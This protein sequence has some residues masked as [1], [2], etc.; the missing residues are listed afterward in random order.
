MV[1]SSGCF[2]IFYVK[3]WLEITK[4]LFKSNRFL[5]FQARMV[6]QTPS[7]FP[8]KI[9][10]FLKKQQTNQDWTDSTSWIRRK[11]ARLLSC[12]F[13]IFHL[14]PSHHIFHRTH[15]NLYTQ[16]NQATKIHIDL[17]DKI[18][19]FLDFISG[20]YRDPKNWLEVTIVAF[21]LES[22]TPIFFGGKCVSSNLT[23]WAVHMFFFQIWVF[24]GEKNKKPPTGCR[25]QLWRT[26]GWHLG[27]KLWRNIRPFGEQKTVGWMSIPSLPLTVFWGRGLI[28]TNRRNKNTMII[29]GGMVVFVG[30]E[31][32]IIISYR[33]FA[34]HRLNAF[35]A[36]REE[37]FFSLIVTLLSSQSFHPRSRNE[38]RIWYVSM[39]WGDLPCHGLLSVI[40]RWVDFIVTV[41]HGGFTIAGKEENMVNFLETTRNL[42]VRGRKH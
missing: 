32:S 22:C 3:K 38:G 8:V 37:T 42:R 14:D 23:N 29:Y 10:P 31:E 15:P 4:D 6:S 27:A 35:W 20:E 34:K 39:S 30:R 1:V 21:F 41:N 12:C 5:G 25:L 7:F 17:Q 19:R 26:F 33:R 11:L 13:T 18:S 9:K 2:Q 40:L 36:D 16:Q 24:F 28:Y